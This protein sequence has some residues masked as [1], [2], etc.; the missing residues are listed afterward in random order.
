MFYPDPVI[1]DQTEASEQ[2]LLNL[3]SQGH[4]TDAIKAYQLLRSKKKGMS[5]KL[6]LLFFRI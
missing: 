4:L 2:L 5:G 6:L 1:D 3:I